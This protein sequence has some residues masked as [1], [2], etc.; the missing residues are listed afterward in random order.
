MPF[1]NAGL[2]CLRPDVT[3]P[4]PF[5]APRAKVDDFGNADLVDIDGLPVSEKWKEKFRLFRKAGAP[6]FSRLKELPA[7]ERKRASFGFNVLAFLFG[8]FYYIAKGMWRRG[9]SLLVVCISAVAA[10]EA[11]LGL[12]GWTM[13]GHALGYGIAAVYAVRANIDYYRKMVLG[14]NGWW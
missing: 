2:S 10:I 13:L 3:N 1:Y 14:D 4:N 6:K 5:A 12:M 7:E 9:L 11:L 8:P